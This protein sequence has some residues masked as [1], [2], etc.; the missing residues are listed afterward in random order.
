[1]NDV[2][3]LIW[4]E[5]LATPSA[6]DVPQALAQTFEVVSANSTADVNAM[7]ADLQ[8]AAVFFD[9]D[10]PDRHRLTL[11]SNTKRQHPSVPVVMVTLQHSE[12]LAIWAYRNGALDYLVK[13]I[14]GGELASCVD[15]LLEINNLK[16]TAK[17]QRSTAKVGTPIPDAVPHAP[18]G[19]KDRLAPAV[20]FVQQHYNRHIYSDAVARLC[21]MS[22]SHFS[23]AFSKSYGLTFQEFLLRY[24]VN[25][26]CKLLHDR[27]SMRIAEVAHC[28][29]FSDPSYFTRVFKR[30]IGVAPSGYR[31]A[32][33]ESGVIASDQ[34]DIEDDLT[35]SSQVVRQLSDSYSS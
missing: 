6:V 32:I 8:P 35:S 26:A 4:L 29:G 10:Y 14:D 21:N 28:V 1:M 2:P 30:Y 27:Q 5:Q 17:G 31:A 34:S 19:P 18:R 24:R 22:A 3:T 20:F 13:P 11:F 23:R 9:F 15:R 12:T 33:E 16:S 7:I 25:R